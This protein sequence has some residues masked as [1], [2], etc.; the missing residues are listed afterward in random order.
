MNQTE[1]WR[2]T[3]EHVLDGGAIGEYNGDPDSNVM[4]LARAVL[5]LLLRVS[6]LEQP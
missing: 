4:E 3:A 2:K 6:E 5:C 1:E